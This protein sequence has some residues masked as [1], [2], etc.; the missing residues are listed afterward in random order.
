MTLD[1]SLEGQEFPSRG[2]GGYCRHSKE[3]QETVVGRH[4]IPGE[5]QSGGAG[6]MWGYLEGKLNRDGTRG[7]C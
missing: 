5:L 6:R 4:V 3:P 2:R 7:S 1:L